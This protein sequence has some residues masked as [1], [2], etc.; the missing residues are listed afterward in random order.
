MYKQLCADD[1]PMVRRAAAKH[2]PKFIKV[3]AKNQV[4]TDILPMF[5]FNFLILV[6]LAQDDQDSVR[7]LTVE[8][9]ISLFEIL[10][11][12]ECKTHLVSYF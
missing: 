1:T 2:L 8:G 9:L 6:S 7:L 3:I 11:P 5:G 10:T 4:I 12:E